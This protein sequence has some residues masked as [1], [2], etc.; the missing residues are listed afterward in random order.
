LSLTRQ[1]LEAEKKSTLEEGGGPVRKDQFP[2][3]KQNPKKEKI[4]KPTEFESV[5]RL[6]SDSGRDIDEVKGAGGVVKAG[7][8]RNQIPFCVDELRHHYFAVD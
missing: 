8:G 4:Q 5:N 2:F 1:L 7:E 6:S 3:K